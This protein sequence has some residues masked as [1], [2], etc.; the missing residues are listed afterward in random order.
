MRA[1]PSSYSTW[2]YVDLMVYLAGSAPE[3][4]IVPPR[5]DVINATH[6]NRLPILGNVFF[7]YRYMGERN[8]FPPNNKQ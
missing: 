1:T 8:E 4:I 2:Q 7:P 3:G 6:T 5:E